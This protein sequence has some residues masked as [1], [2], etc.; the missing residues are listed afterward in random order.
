MSIAHAQLE[1]NSPLDPF[2]KKKGPLDFFPSL[3]LN[4]HS[5]GLLSNLALLASLSLA[6]RT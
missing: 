2:N 6:R 1:G 5:I 4:R 3:S